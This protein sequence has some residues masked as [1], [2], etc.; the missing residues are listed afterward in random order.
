M[1][2]CY[3]PSRFQHA[4][5]YAIVIFYHIHGMVRVC[6]EVGPSLKAIITSLLALPHG[7]KAREEVRRSRKIRQIQLIVKVG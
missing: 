3:F 7:A 6:G 5:S 2:N 1:H 4:S